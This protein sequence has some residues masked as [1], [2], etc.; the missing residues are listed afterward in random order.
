MKILV[1]HSAYRE[2]GG[3]DAV[4]DAEFALLRAFGHEVVEY[5]RDNATIAAVPQLGLLRQAL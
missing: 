5:R 3:E 1:A 2:R 4:V